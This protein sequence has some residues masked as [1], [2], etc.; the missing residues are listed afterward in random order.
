[1]TSYQEAL[2]KTESNTEGKKEKTL[3]KIE[4]LSEIPPQ[5][6][7]INPKTLEAVEFLDENYSELCEVHHFLQSEFLHNGFLN[8]L[9][10]T[11]IQKIID[12]NMTLRARD[13][14]SGLED[15]SDDENCYEE[16]FF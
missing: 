16:E 12:K 15:S 9:I 5:A 3:I 6:T 13:V 8:D 7:T 1:M 4:N 10:V 11:D 14:D 2:T